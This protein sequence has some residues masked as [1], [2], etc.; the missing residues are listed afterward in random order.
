MVQPSTRRGHSA[1]A[2]ESHEREVKAGVSP[3]ANAENAAG[4][5]DLGAD[6]T[7]NDVDDDVAANADAD[8]DEEEVEG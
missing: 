4:V 3:G 2:I 7:V 6:E 5:G 1:A 8:T